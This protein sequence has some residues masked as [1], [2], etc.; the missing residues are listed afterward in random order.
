MTYQLYYWPGI[1][2]RGE[3]VRLALEYAGAPYEDVAREPGGMD[4]LMTGLEPGEAP[5]PSF[6]P[7]Y[8]KD[9][10]LVIGQTAAIL[11]HLGPKLDLAPLTDSGRL[12]THQIQLTIMDLVKEVHDTH[13]PVGSGL[14]YE[15]QKPE[16]QRYAAEFRRHRIGKYLGWLEGILDSHQGGHLVG[17]HVTYA[18]LSAF[19]VVAGLTYAFPKAT[20]RTLFGTPKLKA[21]AEKVAG[22]PRLKPYLESPRRLS[23]NEHGIFRHYPELDG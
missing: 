7:P 14:Y 18:D 11:L 17:G 4:R 21:L 19:H 22:L 10:R 12:W 2:G 9:G 8:L 1:P 20:A 13:H 16:A 5:H 15:D 3:F 23:F 6:A